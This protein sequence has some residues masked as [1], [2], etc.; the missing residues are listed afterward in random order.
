MGKYRTRDPH[1]EKIPP[2][3]LLYRYLVEHGNSARPKNRRLLR[4]VL[5]N[6]YS[7]GSD[8]N[9][10]HLLERRWSDKRPSH[11]AQNPINQPR[12]AGVSDHNTIDL[13]MLDTMGRFETE[14]A[15]LRLPLPKTGRGSAGKK[16]Q[17]LGLS[18]AYI[19]CLCSIFSP[20]LAA[21]LSYSLNFRVVA[22]G[23]GT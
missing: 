4:T 16:T 6:I 8:S 15:L 12:M 7:S 17:C 20:K 18:H 1:V 21:L 2:S 10:C 9:R 3:S 13:V 22:V 23:A 14:S 5:T 19:A 11:I